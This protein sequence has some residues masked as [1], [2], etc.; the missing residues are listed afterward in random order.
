[1]ENLKLRHPLFLC[2]MMGSGKSTVGKTLA[3]KLDVPFSDLDSMIVDEAGLSIPQIFEQKGETW[4]R[5]LEKKILIRES[6]I[7]DGI[8]ALG[9]GSLQDQQIVDHLKI[10]G[11]LIFLKVPKT[12]ILDRIAGDLNRPM[13]TRAKE[14]KD[15]SRD[16]IEALIDRRLPFY[17][18]AQITI[19]S[20][21]SSPTLIAD[22]I[23]KKLKIYDG[24]SK[25]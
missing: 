16:T 11:W 7:I 25:R 12:V 19:D 8:M 10:C 15:Q 13:L 4:F 24:F 22:N 21:D 9:G 3:K 5:Q 18:Q 1:M 14:S 17:N 2:G 20:H 6:Q 23:I